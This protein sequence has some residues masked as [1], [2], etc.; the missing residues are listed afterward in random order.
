MIISNQCKSLIH[1]ID[2]QLLENQHAVDLYS[3]YTKVQ[4]F[5]NLLVRHSIP[6]KKQFFMLTGI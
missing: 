4:C 1:C 5:G 3:R 6:L 2:I